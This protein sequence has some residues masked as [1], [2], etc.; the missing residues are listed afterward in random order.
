MNLVRFQSHDTRESQGGDRGRWPLAC[1][2][3]WAH[4]DYQREE[5][6]EGLDF[7]SG[8]GLKTCLSSA[9]F[10]SLHS[11][12]QDPLL[13]VPYLW[14]GSG[15]SSYDWPWGSD[16]SHEVVRAPTWPPWLKLS[17]SCQHRPVSVGQRWR[18]V[19]VPR[20][21][22]QASLRELEPPI[23]K[24]RPQSEGDEQDEQARLLGQPGPGLHV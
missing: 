2:L 24:H 22:W 23:L 4:E 16:C 1:S 17:W 9:S 10:P 8:P 18:N 3:W 13:T 6:W 15:Q 7:S 5:P 20:H 19:S 12:G 14:E 11:Q 21:R